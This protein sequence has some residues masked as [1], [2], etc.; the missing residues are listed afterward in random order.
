MKKAA[1]TLD[2]LGITYDIDIMSAHRTPEK[3]TAYAKEAK[4]KGIKVIICGAGLSAHLAGV[5][6][7]H[8]D[9]PV[10]G[11]PLGSA[12]GLGGIDALLS[13]SQMPKGVPVA[14]VAINGA[15][16]AALLAA[17]ILALSDDTLFKKLED[18]KKEMQSDIEAAS[19]KLKNGVNPQ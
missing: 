15:M 2:K 4:S 19:K 6:A 3:V 16:N 18:L 11:V 8:T 12:Q 9:L 5:V 7:A 14:T 10:I 13:T 1:D 17:K